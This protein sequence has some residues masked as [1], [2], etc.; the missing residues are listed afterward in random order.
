MRLGHDRD[1]GAVQ[2]REYVDG[3]LRRLPAAVNDKHDGNR[4]HK[5]A[6]AQTERDDVVEHSCVKLRAAQDALTSPIG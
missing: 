3:E 6:V 2:V 4:Q 5:N 1:R